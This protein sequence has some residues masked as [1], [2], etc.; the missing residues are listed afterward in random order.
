MTTSKD[1]KQSSN[2]H[3]EEDQ[4]VDVI[5]EADPAVKILC[6]HCG[7]TSTNG[8]RCSREGVCY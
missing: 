7:R 6:Q 5:S 2:V 4:A 8:I 3:N 1:K